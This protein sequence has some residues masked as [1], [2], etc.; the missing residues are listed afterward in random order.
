VV[1]LFGE[2]AGVSFAPDGD[3]LFIGVSGAT[4]PP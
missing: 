2:L 1:D 4:L 3:R